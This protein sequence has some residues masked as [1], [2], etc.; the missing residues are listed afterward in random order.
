MTVSVK[1]TWKVGDVEHSAEFTAPDE[2]ALH[3][4]LYEFGLI[5]A[6]FEEITKT[7]YKESDE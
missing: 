1:R 3:L 7:E 5:A 4:L 6:M 2:K